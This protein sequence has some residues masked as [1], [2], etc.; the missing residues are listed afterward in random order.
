ME[1]NEDQYKEDKSNYNYVDFQ[2]H[3]NHLKLKEI[4]DIL[5]ITLKEYYNICKRLNMPRTTKKVLT[6]IDDKMHFMPKE[7]ID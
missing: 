5:K 7:K 2:Y 6:R 1:L 4:C 3:L